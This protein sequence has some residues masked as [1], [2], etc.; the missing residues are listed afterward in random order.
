MYQYPFVASSC[1]FARGHRGEKEYGLGD[2]ACRRIAD[3]RHAT[4][5]R[6]PVDRPGEYGLR[7]AGGD[8]QRDP[9]SYSPLGHHFV[10]EEDEVRADEQLRYY[11]DARQV[12][13]AEHPLRSGHVVEAGD[14]G[15]GGD[16]VAKHLRDGLHEDHDDDQEL[17]GPLVHRL[18]LVV[19]K[20]ELD[21]LRADEQLHDDRRGDDRAD[22][23][24]HQRTLR[25]GK[26]R[27][28]RTEDVDDPA[29]VQSKE[30]HVGHYEVEDQHEDDPHDLGPEVHVPLRPLDRWKSIRERLQPVESAVL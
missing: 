6:V 3:G 20:V 12:G 28:I 30:E 26:D 16:Q 18:V 1:Q 24:M 21:D 23:Q 29:L 14:K 10:H 15:I 17:L 27:P 13:A 5:H 19:G 7:Y 25:A 9:A 8:E 2:G 11:D 22:A 4:F